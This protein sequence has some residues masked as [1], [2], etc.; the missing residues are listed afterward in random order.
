MLCLH[1]A[2]RITKYWNRKKEK[3]Y[4]R[5]YTSLYVCLFMFFFFSKHHGIRILNIWIMCNNLWTLWI[6]WKSN[7][8][9]FTEWSFQTF[10]QERPVNSR[11]CAGQP[12]PTYTNITS[13]T[14]MSF[15]S[16][17]QSAV[18]G[19]SLIYNRGPHLILQDLVGVAGTDFELEGVTGAYGF[20]LQI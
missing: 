12:G 13:D 7:I 16:K 8:K 4:T 20:N 11:G 10:K 15:Y 6:Y 3:V 19:R 14:N 5:K 2:F 9:K 18:A 1:R 17:K